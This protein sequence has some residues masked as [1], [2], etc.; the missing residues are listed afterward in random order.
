MSRNTLQGLVHK[1]A[2]ALLRTAARA[3]YEDWLWQ[4]T[5]AGERAEQSIGCRDLTM[6]DLSRL[7]DLLRDSGAL[8]G[9]ARGGTGAG[10]D[11]PTPKQWGALAALS[12]DRGWIGLDDH[13]LQQMCYRTCR[14]SHTRFLDRNGA[15]KLITGMRRW[16][17]QTDGDQQ[18]AADER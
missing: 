8:D 3:P 12:R 4:Q 15:S 11:R 2:T 6:A 1:G 7:V 18:P 17:G 13:R 16:A 10:A 9:P 5:R 14:V